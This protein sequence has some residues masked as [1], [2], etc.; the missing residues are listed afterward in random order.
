MAQGYCF[1][2]RKET[3]APKCGRGLSGK[4]VP[5]KGPLSRQSFAP[6]STTEN[7]CLSLKKHQS[8]QAAGWQACGMHLH[9]CT[10]A[11]RVPYLAL[12][13]KLVGKI[14]CPGLQTPTSASSGLQPRGVH[15]RGPKQGCRSGSRAE[16]GHFSLGFGPACRKAAAHWTPLFPNP[17]ARRYIWVLE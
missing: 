14:T 5:K 1:S 8:S 11:T 7:A 15:S 16:Q 12:A 2:A 13:I 10:A 9:F 3:Q 17:I 6:D 4:T